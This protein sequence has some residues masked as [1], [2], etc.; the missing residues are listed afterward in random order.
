MCFGGG[1]AAFKAY[2]PESSSK[3]R[4]LEFQFENLYGKAAPDVNGEEGEGG[5]EGQREGV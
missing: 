4:R 1:G 3:G 5:S 2:W